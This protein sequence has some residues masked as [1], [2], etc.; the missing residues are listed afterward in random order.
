MNTPKWHLLN[1]LVESGIIAI[2]RRIPEVHIE[3]V[4]THLVKGGVTTLEIT[5]DTPGAFR[6]IETL[7]AKF[8]DAV[9]IG[10]GTVLDSDTARRAIE[11]GASFILS[12]TLHEGVIRTTI[13]YGQI[14][15]PGV[16]T[17][18]EIVQAMEWGADAVKV[19]PA[20]VLGPQ[21]IQALQ[22]PLPHIP[23]I[24]TGG[25]DANNISL[26]IKSGAVAVG[27]GSS[28]TDRLAIDRSDYT[29]IEARAREYVELVSH[30]RTNK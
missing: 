2:I 14:S 8:G 16:M 17:P 29:T 22:A 9:L 21:Y 4:V 30:A 10:A 7:R 6:A 20:D 23:M 15:I 3:P 28:L 11:S 5:V 27:V 24:P 12:P 19:F 1:R 18:T 26:Y 25:I 13:R